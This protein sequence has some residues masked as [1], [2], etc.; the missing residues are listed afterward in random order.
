VIV[1]GRCIMLVLARAGHPVVLTRVTDVTERSI[2][3]E[4]GWI[5]RSLEGIAWQLAE[6]LDTDSARTLQAAT[7]LAWSART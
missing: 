5:P 2:Q 4:Y 3:T 7:L 6:H 1:P